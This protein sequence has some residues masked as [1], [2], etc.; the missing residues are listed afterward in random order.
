MGHYNSFVVRFWTDRGKG[1]SRGHIQHV[2]SRD[3]AYFV[4]HKKMNE[5]IQDHMDPPTEAP[6]EGDTD[7]TEAHCDQ[8]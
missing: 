1:K 3:D 5:F 2:S 6:I 4:V 8:V 7:L